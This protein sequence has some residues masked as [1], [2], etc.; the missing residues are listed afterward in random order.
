M[1][2]TKR[3]NIC[4][5]K[6]ESVAALNKFAEAMLKSDDH[7]TRMIGVWTKALATPFLDVVHG[8]SLTAKI[9]IADDEAA[10][11]E[12]TRGLCDDAYG[13]AIALASLASNF[14]MAQSPPQL[15]E[16]LAQGYFGDV[17]GTELSRMLSVSC[18]AEAELSKRLHSLGTGTQQ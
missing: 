7:A 15:R 9:T 14:L 16:N 11:T 17:Y 8:D 18:K 6:E 2:D 13:L 12:K 1:I 5:N 10:L 4:D 3:V